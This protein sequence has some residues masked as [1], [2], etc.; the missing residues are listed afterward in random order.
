LQQAHSRHGDDGLTQTETRVLRFTQASSQLHRYRTGVSLHSHTQYSRECLEYLP[1]QASRIPVIGSMVQA[2]IRRYEEDNGKP[3]D[4]RRAW[5]TPPCSPAQVY[6][7]EA[8]QIQALGLAPL[9]S[10]TDHDSVEAGLSLQNHPAPEPIPV[11]VEWSVPVS[12]DYLHIGVH[13]LPADRAATIMEALADF[14]AQPDSCPDTLRDLFAFL[15]G[16]P[17]TLIVLN[18]PCW[19]VSRVGEAH[20]MTAVR[21]FLTLCESYVHAVEINGLRAWKENCGAL[22][23]AEQC[24]LPVIAGGD[25]HGCQPNAVLNLSTAG[26]WGEFVSEVRDDAHAQV[27]LLPAYEQPLGLRQLE[28]VA[29]ALR[30]YPTHPHGRRRFT[31]R[32]F[33]DLPGY[34][35][36]PLSFYWDGGPPLWLR[37]VL[38]TIV[39][40]GS[41]R[42]RPILRRTLFR[43][44][45]KDL[46]VQ[47]EHVFAPAAPLPQEVVQ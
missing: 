26:S 32:T 9:V 14:T 35:P 7:S 17:Q 12:G 27:L 5:W 18:H 1:C 24:G 4:F 31:S 34:S 16:D 2:R 19:D 44:S 15:A 46:M 38:A 39:A 22:A 3:L 45:E 28:T 20:H 33:A 6:T 43:R 10:I 11:S 29:D 8:E 30:Y 21:E 41:E 25:R 36:H 42:A 37:P 23:V 40:L 13:H 47:A